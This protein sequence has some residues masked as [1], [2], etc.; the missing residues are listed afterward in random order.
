[1]NEVLRIKRKRIIS[2]YSHEANRAM[3]GLIPDSFMVYKQEPF[4]KRARQLILDHAASLANSLVKLHMEM[5]ENADEFREFE[6][7]IRDA[8]AS[9]LDPYFGEQNPEESQFEWSLSHEEMIELVLEYTYEE[10]VLAALDTENDSDAPAQEVREGELK[11]TTDKW[12]SNA[13]AVEILQREMGF[14]E[15]GTAQS[16]L[17][18]AKK[19]EQVRRLGKGKNSEVEKGSLLMFIENRKANKEKQGKRYDDIDHLE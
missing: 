18:N 12:I 1:M 6:D 10:W 15:T 16:T 13:E 8:I 3:S 17:S 14:P 7:S 19:D 4:A 9:F 2:E 11:L 5:G